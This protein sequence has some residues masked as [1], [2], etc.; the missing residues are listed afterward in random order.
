MSE[1]LYHLEKYSQIYMTAS[2]TTGSDGNVGHS[3][4]FVDL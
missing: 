2:R 4:G 3:D 1:F